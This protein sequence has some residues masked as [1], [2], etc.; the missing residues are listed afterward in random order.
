MRRAA[1]RRRATRGAAAGILV[2]AMLVLVGCARIPTSGQ[3][4]AGES[5]QQ[6]SDQSY[7]FFPDPPRDGMSREEVIEGF[8][9]AGT[10]TQNDYE[11]AREYLDESFRQEWDPNARIIVTASV[12][13]VVDDGSDRVEASY[14]SSASVDA[15]GIYS[16]L[17]SGTTERLD[18]TL[19]QNADGEWRITEAP[20]GIVLLNQNFRSLFKSYTLYFY[21]DT[22]SRLV[23]DVRWFDAQQ[24]AMTRIARALVNGPAP[25]LAEGN[26]VS[27]IPSDVTLLGAVTVEGDVADVDFSSVLSSAS[28]ERYSR[29][30]LQLTESFADFESITSVTMSITGVPIDQDLP[31]EDAVVV[32]RQVTSTP[33]VYKGGELGFLSGV[34]VTASPET[35]ALQGAIASLTPQK[36]AY[37]SAGDVASFVTP[38]GVYTTP[39]AVPDPL[40]VDARPGPLAMS[41]DSWGYTWTGSTDGSGLRATDVDDRQHS[42]LEPAENVGA[43]GYRSIAVSRDGARLAVLEN[44]SVGVKVAVM[45]IER[46]PSTNRPIA[47]GNPLI[48]EPGGASPIDLAWVDETSLAVL[49]TGSEGTAEVRTQTVGGTVSVNGAVLEGQ[50]ITGSNTPAGLRVL[51]KDR[52][53]YVPKGN[54]WQQSEAVVDFILT[55]V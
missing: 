24:T 15:E 22:L 26:V 9:D 37:S 31:P 4:L 44:S 39:I 17:K 8:L 16:E 30:L 25:W 38:N 35:A 46:E 32:N 18:F 20:P 1:N 3:V 10:G 21:D 19:A 13:D 2:I 48:L 42:W 12:P 45:A 41:L 54:R 11:V 51:D 40:L 34:N 47:L 33:L 53:I 23:P 55:Q 52:H 5:E 36:G 49:A 43:T 29:M 27:A 50:Q 6:E 28:P 14:K 7:S